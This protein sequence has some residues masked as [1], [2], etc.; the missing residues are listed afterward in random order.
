MDLRQHR[1]AEALVPP[2]RAVVRLVAGAAHERPRVL[3][4]EPVAVPEA[5]REGHRLPQGGPRELVPE[6]PDGARERAG[7]RRA[8][9]AL[10]IRRH[11]EG[12]DAVVLPRHRLRR[13]PARRPEPARGCMAVEGHLHAAQLDRPLLGRRRRVRDRG[14]RRAGLGVHDPPRHALRGDLH[15]GGTR[16]RARG[17]AR[18]RAHPPRCRPASRTTSTRS[19]PRA[20]STGSPPSG[21][22]R[23]SS[24]SGTRSTR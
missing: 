19:A 10:R 13:P 21:R 11:E 16:L 9:R 3:Q 14:P 5:L 23:A 17:R 4:V 1:A 7:H 8:L 15:G 24:S 22:R 6:R 12:A 2:V 18:R 20:T